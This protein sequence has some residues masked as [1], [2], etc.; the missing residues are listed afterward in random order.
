MNIRSDSETLRLSCCSSFHSM[1]VENIVWFYLTT[2]TVPA[3]TIFSLSE[4][5]G[6]AYPKATQPYTL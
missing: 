3:F 5:L 2:V 4:I 6:S 1:F